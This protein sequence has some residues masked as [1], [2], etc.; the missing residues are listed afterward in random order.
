MSTIA[1]LRARITEGYKKS[2]VVTA[3]LIVLTVIVILWAVKKLAI[4]LGLKESRMTAGIGNF[5]IPGENPVWYPG[6]VNAGEWGSMDSPLTPQQL[7]VFLPQYNRDYQIAMA[8]HAASR[9]GMASGADGGACGGGWEPAAI[10]EAQG[11]E[12]AQG[13][14]RVPLIAAMAADKRL[15][16]AGGNV[17]NLSKYDTKSEIADLWLGELANK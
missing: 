10:A 15:R 16:A 14:E 8:K 6:S 7:G 9:E 12:V 1:K 13:L 11:L 3:V 17:Q 4:M 2:P 5:E